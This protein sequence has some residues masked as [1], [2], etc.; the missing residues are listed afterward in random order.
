VC[1]C[2]DETV[3]E[4]RA[5]YG[6]ECE[7]SN[8]HNAFHADSHTHTHTQIHTHTPALLSVSPY[9]SAKTTVITESPIPCHS[10]HLCP[11]GSSAVCVCVCVNVCVCV[12]MCE[13]VLMCVC[14]CLCASVC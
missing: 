4:H 2:G 1:V 6:H 10:V 7:D 12:L 5:V 3:C 13:C 14:V 9:K 11:S 8:A